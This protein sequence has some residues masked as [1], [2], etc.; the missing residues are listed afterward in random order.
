[1]IRSSRAGIVVSQKMADYDFYAPA[2][3]AKENYLGSF[4]F[5]PGKH[6]LRLECV[7]RNPLAKG[8]HLGLD[9]VRLRDRWDKKRKPLL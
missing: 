5:T 4:K 8:K 9:S 1:M 2:L 3:Q 7:G 6:T